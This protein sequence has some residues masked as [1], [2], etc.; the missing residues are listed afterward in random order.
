MTAPKSE[1]VVPREAVQR[2]ILAA[3]SYGVRYLDSDDM[4]DEAQEIQDAT[5][6]MKDH[7]AAAPQPEA[8]GEDLREGVARIVSPDAFR[9]RDRHY[10]EIAKL[11]AD[12]HQ[13]EERAADLR[14]SADAYP[15]RAFNK[16]D[17][18]LA[19]IAA[20]RRGDGTGGEGFQ[21]R[22]LPWLME[23]FG[24]EIA[25]DRVERCDR[26]I[27]EALELAQSLEWPK[28]RALA[29]V[30]YVYG[31]PAGEPHQEVGGCICVQ[32]GD[33]PEGCGICNETGRRGPQEGAGR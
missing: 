20:S 16:A 30:E 27:E 26:F 23:C 29:L 24:A 7:L 28:E 12:G 5:E 13:T 4:T 22:V 17:S 19:L 10:A 21:A 6:A 14:R 18:I 31:R 1:V 8:E 2:L 15:A 32:R 9:T 3:D 25:A 11:V 33:G